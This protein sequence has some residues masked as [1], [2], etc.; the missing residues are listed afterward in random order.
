VSSQPHPPYGDFVRARRLSGNRPTSDL[1][2]TDC[3][4]AIAYGDARVES[5]TAHSNYTT[6]DP[7]YPLIAEASEYFASS[8]IIDHYESE[9]TKG[10]D[11]YAKAMD[12]CFSIR[13]S[14]PDSLFSIPGMYMTYP[15]NPTQPMYRSLPGGGIDP[16]WGSGTQDGTIQSE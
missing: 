8:W 7:I 15:L 16:G 2:D 6:D 3:Q 12:I 9:S 4:Q 1:S 10:D 5:E 13:E 14:S 11:H